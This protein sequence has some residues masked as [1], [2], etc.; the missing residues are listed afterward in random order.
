[1]ERCLELA[2]NGLGK[3][4][5][6][7]MVGAVIVLDGNIIGEG[8]H[9]KAGT[10]HAEVHA[11][12]SVSN[13]EVLKDATIYVSL[14]PCSHH[15]RTPPCADLIIEKGFKK[16]VVAA[17]DP[18]P[19]VGGRGIERIRN[20]G[21]EVEVGVLEAESKWLNRRFFTVQEKKR[22]HVILKWAQSQ[23]DFIAPTHREQTGPV[24]ISSKWSKQWVHKLRAQEQAILVGTQTA[25]DDDP[26]LTTR[27]WQG[28][29]PLR[30]LI[31]RKRLVPETAQILNEDAPTLIF[32]EHPSSK[33]TSYEMLDANFESNL[34]QQILKTLYERGVQSLIVEGGQKTLQGFIDLDLWDEAYRIT[35]PIEFVSGVSAPRLDAELLETIQIGPDMVEHL[36][37]SHA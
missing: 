19:I 7:P 16:V 3:T 12:R 6:N 24:W 28:P 5:P 17:L 20:A 27:N 10:P 32:T 25:L 4:Y 13:H 33:D 11:V 31:D 21:I 23:N 37:P 18:N 14:E 15:G 1:M 22:P 35:G 26:S 34:P 36:I 9:Q 30:V 2:A 29:N 8:W